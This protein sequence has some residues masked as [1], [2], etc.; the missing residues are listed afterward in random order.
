M[1]ERTIG[2]DH[3]IYAITLTG[4]LTKVVDLL[5]TA[6]RA[7]YDKFI[8]TKVKNTGTHGDVQS[9]GYRRMPVDGYVVNPLASLIVASGAATAEETVDAGVQ[10]TCPIAFWL[11]KLYV[12]GSGTATVRIFFS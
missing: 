2:G 12:K 9:D 8:T 7:E 3:R 10:Y 11:D 1:Y 4:S 5:N 6:D